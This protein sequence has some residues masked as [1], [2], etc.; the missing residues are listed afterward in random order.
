MTIARRLLVLCFAASAAMAD[1]SKPPPGAPWTMDFGAALEAASK[2][3]K[4]IFL[5]FTKTY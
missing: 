3:G 1:S 4:P 2:S 5:Y